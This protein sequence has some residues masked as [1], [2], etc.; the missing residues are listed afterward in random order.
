MS[1]EENPA[2][3]YAQVIYNP[4]PQ[5]LGSG[6][7]PPDPERE[8]RSEDWSLGNILSWI[9]FREPALLCEYGSGFYRQ[10]PRSGHIGLGSSITL[11]R[12]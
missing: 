2:R 6:D 7:D 5:N 3:R 12:R 1:D 4:P 9:A 10:V 8:F 11:V